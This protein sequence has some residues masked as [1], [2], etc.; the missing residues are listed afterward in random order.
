MNLRNLNDL[1]K[2]EDKF[3]E[4]KVILNPVDAPYICDTIVNNI[5]DEMLNDLIMDMMIN[6]GYNRKKILQIAK[7]IN[8]IQS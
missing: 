3:G 2:I 8:Q 6:M 7:I 1:Q 5:N 4:I